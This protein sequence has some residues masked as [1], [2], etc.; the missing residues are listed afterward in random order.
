V[1]SEI[2]GKSLG[3]GM[4]D[5]ENE[6]GFRL[7]Q[8]ILENGRLQSE[9]SRLR[10]ILKRIEKHKHCCGPVNPKHIYCIKEDKFDPQLTSYLAGVSEG[11]RHCAMIAA[12]A[13]EK[14]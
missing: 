9:N 3:G 14:K 6:T 12:E 13:K 5:A 7:S 8:L 10:R 4:M 11:H 1:G 2:L